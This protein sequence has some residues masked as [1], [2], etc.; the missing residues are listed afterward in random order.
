MTAAA[1]AALFVLA[2]I[3]ALVSYVERV[4]TE[5]GKFLSRDF[6][7]NVEIYERLIEPRIGFDRSRIVLTTQVLTQLCTALLALVLGFLIFNE[8][9]WIGSE[10]L[11]AIVALVFVIIVFNCLVPFIFFSR[12]KGEWL[13]PFVPVLKALVVLALPI[14]IV[15]GFCL[16]VAALAKPTEEQETENSSEAVDAL[17]EA[18][19]E[20]GILEESDRALIQSVVEFG[21]KTVRD[22]MTPRPEMV[23][24]SVNTSIE[25]LTEKLK[26][27]SYSRMPVFEGSI[28]N[29]KGI[30]FTHDLL[31]IPDTEARSRKVSSIMRPAYF[32]PEPKKV[33]ELLREMQREN[34]HMAMVIDEY[35][36]IAGLVTMEDLLEEIVGEIRDEHEPHSDVVRERDEVYIVPGNLDIDRLD[37]LFG[38]RPKEDVEATTVGGLVSEVLGRIPREGEAL[39]DGG[40]RF[41]VLNSTDRRVERL[42]ICRT[43]MEPERIRA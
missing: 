1:I 22:V 23:A 35:G 17:I 32:V 41:E 38:I 9:R 2:G 7:D 27:T 31:Q 4:Y 28:D 8:R 18:G 10:I 26:S 33:S 24:V 15:L 14:T 39:E 11:Q 20:E 34:V 29:I 13:V 3:L 42:R 6:L 37:D 12:T 40:L 36:G 25:Q 5:M 43:P 16:S 19:Q 21:D 30:V